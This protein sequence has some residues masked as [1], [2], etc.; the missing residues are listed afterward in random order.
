MIAAFALPSAT[1]LAQE[2]KW[3]ISGSAGYKFGGGFDTQYNNE[4]IRVN[5]KSGVEYGFGIGY[6]FNRQFM[7]EAAW[8]QQSSAANVRP[9]SG[10]PEVNAFDMKINQF[11][12]NFIWHAY[13]RNPKVRPYFLLGLGAT[14]FRP[15][16]EPELTSTTRFSFALGGG[17]KYWASDSF[18]LKLQ[19]RWTPT[20]INSSPGGVWCDPFF[21]WQTVNNQYA[22]QFDV[23]GSLVVRF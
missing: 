15:D 8:N 13:N 6:N 4:N 11:H 14:T 23:T 18:G 2:G 16:A 20:Y 22:G 3:E 17:V 21:C 9:R 1:A 5:L 19:G 10:G 12:G 7:F